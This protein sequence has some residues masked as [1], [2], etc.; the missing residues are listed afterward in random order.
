M[1]QSAHRAIEFHDSKLAAVSRVGASVVLSFSAAY[2]HESTGVPGIDAGVGWYQ[3]ATLTIAHG[4][5]ASDT[6]LPAGVADGFIRVAG[7]LHQNH[8]PAAAG[9][10]DGPIELSLLLS[11]ADTLLVRGAAITIELSG[12][13]SPIEHFSP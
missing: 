13:P 5:I 3:P 7:A 10:L 12:Q 9:T 8:I 2:V 4:E 1:S 6:Q 11:T